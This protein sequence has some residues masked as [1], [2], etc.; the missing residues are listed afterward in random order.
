VEGDG[1][2]LSYR[3]L[4]ARSCR[5]AQSLRARGVA[6]GARV[7]VFMERS[8][9]MIVGLLGILKAGAAYVPLDPSFPRERLA[10]M[11]EDSAPAV[12]LCD[13]GVEPPTRGVPTVLVDRE[14]AFDGSGLETTRVRPEDAAYVIYTSGS[15]GQPKGVEVAHRS[16]V[17]LLESMRRAMEVGDTDVMLSIT[18]LSFDIT[19][20]EVFLPLF[21]GARLVLASREEALDGHRLAQRMQSS[22]ATVMQGTPATWR[23]L[24]EAG[25]PGTPG[26]KVLCGGEAWPREL[27]NELRRRASAVWNGYGPTETTVC[28]TLWRIEPGEGP[29]SIGRP[30]ANTT[31]YVLDEH[32]EPRPVGVPGELYIGGVGVAR[33]YWRRPELTAERFL[34]D[35]FSG[36]NAARLYRSGDL[37]R[38]LPDGRLEYLGRMDQQ[39]KIRG[40]RIEVGE[41][42][43]VLSELPGVESAVVVASGGGPQDRRLV[44]FLTGAPET[45]SEPAALREHLRSRLPAYMVPSSLVAVE[46]LPLTPTGKVDRKA[47]EI[48]DSGAT[49]P[50]AD[51][52]APRTPTEETMASIWAATLEASSL[53]VHDNFFEAGGHSLGAARIV[54][55][56]RSAFGVDVGMRSLFERPTVASLSELVDMLLLAGGSPGAQTGADRE[57]MEF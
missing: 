21:S 37:V 48:M 40:F 51:H 2:T 20:F 26:L 1:R 33:G 45:L 10:Y 56:L 23:L 9:E 11:V 24:I 31:L 12:L 18:T 14:E 13:P 4:A 25:W 36:E 49:V 29:L 32:R 7:G 34:P 3:E 5:V 16:L 44:A 17:N 19:A 50:R 46:R 57:E 6:A 41:I 28:S 52:V 43:A 54:T 55:Q 8:P 27:A 42:E 47:L 39:V 30:L 38:W 15:T 35:P 22:A 53:G